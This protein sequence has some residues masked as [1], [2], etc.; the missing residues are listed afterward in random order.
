[1]CQC[2]RLPSVLGITQAVKLP[3]EC[4]DGFVTALCDLRPYENQG[5]EAEAVIGRSTSDIY[6]NFL[7]SMANPNCAGQLD[8]NPDTGEERT[9]PIEKCLHSTGP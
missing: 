3:I 8:T 9:T 4:D 5:S 7:N 1:V 6:K 2:P